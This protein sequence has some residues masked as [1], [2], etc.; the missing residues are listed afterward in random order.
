MSKALSHFSSQEACRGA[1]PRRSEQ[2]AEGWGPVWKV[3][4]VEVSDSQL[5]GLAM[6][7][8]PGRTALLAAASPGPGDPQ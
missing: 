5:Q 2:E 4:E 8:D 7:H 6:G 3:G 1:D